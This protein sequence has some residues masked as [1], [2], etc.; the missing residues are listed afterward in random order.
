MLDITSKGNTVVFSTKDKKEII[1]DTSSS[2]V[3]LDKLDVNF[4]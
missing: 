4:P 3:V 2:Q 1:F